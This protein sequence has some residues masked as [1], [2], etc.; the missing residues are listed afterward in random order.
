MSFFRRLFSHFGEGDGFGGIPAHPSPTPTKS[1]AGSRSTELKL[2]AM[3]RLNKQVSPAA[4][5]RAEAAR[6]AARERQAKTIAQTM[7]TAPAGSAARVQAQ[8]QVS[9]IVRSG[10]VDQAVAIARAAGATGAQVQRIIGTMTGGAGGARA[11]ESAFGP[12][13]LRGVGLGATLTREQMAAL[14]AAQANAAGGG[15]SSSS[16]SSSSTAPTDTGPDPYGV[17][18]GYTPQNRA[19]LTADL[20]AETPDAQSWHFGGQKM[21]H[22]IAFPQVDNSAARNYYKSSGRGGNGYT[23][24]FDWRPAGVSMAD[25]T[26]GRYD[27]SGPPNLRWDFAPNRDLSKG[28]NL[29]ASDQILAIGLPLPRRDGIRVWNPADLHTWNIVPGEYLPSGWQGL[30]FIY[31]A[32]GL[33]SFADVPA[34]F[35]RYDRGVGT[36]DWFSLFGVPIDLID[37]ARQGLVPDEAAGQDPVSFWTPIL[38]EF[39]LGDR[40]GPGGIGGITIYDV[41][42]PPGYVPP[43]PTAT[44]TSA[45]PAPPPDGSTVDPTAASMTENA[46]GGVTAETTS[47]P[48]SD[49]GYDTMGPAAP[50]G[51]FPDP[52]SLGPGLYPL[53]PEASLPTFGPAA[54]LTSE[55]LEGGT[56]LPDG[57]VLFPDGT[58]IPTGG[59]A[60]AAADVSDDLLVLDDGTV[61]APD[62]TVLPAAGMPLS[63]DSGYLPSNEEMA[64]QAIAVGVEQ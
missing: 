46:G 63:D 40:G 7:R 39:G 9:R 53:G 30:G 38:N 25:P 51:Y 5:A 11:R 45:P 49:G 55:A 44:D 13:G 57:S 50:S 19:W 61:I 34:D 48:V 62:G 22:R 16:S 10:D 31:P 20:N 54:P 4:V 12:S 33:P 52:S 42:L 29:F 36:P 24:N 64:R 1:R 26:L 35:W 3:A 21:R 2:I 15:A 27:S 17:P 32:N 23:G 60:D 14:A 8:R 37:Y 6:R 18:A 41:S 47:L 58:V 43:P 28:G 56:L 59:V